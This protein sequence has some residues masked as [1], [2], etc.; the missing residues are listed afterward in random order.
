MVSNSLI[1][2]VSK[3][4]FSPII[5]LRPSNSFFNLSLGQFA[6][7][8]ATTVKSATITEFRI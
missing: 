6:R 4:C 3:K 5:N 7:D 8:S 1:A 2:G